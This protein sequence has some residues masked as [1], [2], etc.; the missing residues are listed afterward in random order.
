MSM[1]AKNGIES[2]ETKKGV[3]YKVRYWKP[4]GKQG[5]KGSFLTRSAAKAFQ[6]EMEVKRAQGTFVDPAHGRVTLASVAEEWLTAR[7]AD[8]STKRSTFSRVR[9]IVRTRIVP[10]LG[11]HRIGAVTRGDVHEWIR[12][13]GGEA[14]TVRKHVSALRGIFE[15]AIEHNRIHTNPAAKVK[16]PRI[17]KRPKRYLTDEQV[18]TLYDIVGRTN[19][20]AEHGYDLI[21]PFLAYT[22]LRWSELAGLRIRDI[23]L[24]GRRLT[25]EHTVVLVDGVPA[26]GV[27]KSYAVRS[28]PIPGFLVDLLRA[29]IVRR[30]EELAVDSARLKNQLALL[31]AKSAELERVRERGVVLTA[32]LA[33]VREKV[34]TLTDRITG[35]EADREAREAAGMPTEPVEARIAVAT[36]TLSNLPRIEGLELNVERIPARIASLEK[37]L[38]KAPRQAEILRDAIRVLEQEPL[39]VGVRTRTWLRNASFRRGWLSPAVAEL[40]ALTAKTAAENDE[41]PPKPLGDVRPHELRHT[42]AS[43]AISEGANV[44]AL[45]RALGHEK[46]SVTLDVY[47]DLFE[48]DL[49]DVAIRLDNRVRAMS[50]DTDFSRRVSKTCPNLEDDPLWRDVA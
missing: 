29:H 20:G 40:D 11:E 5:S 10:D 32:R 36:K 23:D 8:P 41:I 37:Q 2:Y 7:E 3:R 22:G 6:L 4:G 49:D 13:L 46:A 47:A 38:A 18:A 48:D 45:Q 12:S 24:K 14:E 21:V 16:Q 27:P 43:L 26:E 35:L 31:D 42:Y 39:F 30:R 33:E 50:E 9:G 17:V 28:V 15:Y 1:A 19:S 25:V 44:K 34:A